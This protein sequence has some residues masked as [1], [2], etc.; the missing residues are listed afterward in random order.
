[1]SLSVS[2]LAE[3]ALTALKGK[4]VSK[5]REAG[6]EVDIRMRLR[7]EDRDS[8]Q[9]VQDLLV[10]SPL[11]ISVPLGSV[12]QVKKGFGPSEILR[13]DQERAVLVSADLAGRS[14]VDVSKDVEKI[15]ALYKNK[16]GVSLTPAGEAARMAESFRNLKIVMSL[17]ILFVFM[18]MAA[19]FESLWEPFLILFSI[20]FSLIA[21]APALFIFRHEVSAMAA[22]GVVLLGGIVVNNGIVLFDF[23]NHARHEGHPL[24]ESLR[25]GCS[26]RL[27]PIL[28][29]AL[30][31]I[32]GMTPLALGI[33][34][35]ADL[36]A[37]LAVVVTS[38]LL[39]STALTLVV[40]PA[41]F[42]LVDT[43]LF[44]PA[45]RKATWASLMARIG[46]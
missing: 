41:I 15:L 32:L 1:M 13:Y 10:H 35:G 44:D 36:Q 3:T 5:Y 37:P 23:V 9:A 34:E 8:P 45:G 21:M 6:R 46:R 24:L 38:G 12:A 33:G 30:T 29:T 28:M 4:V 20:P 31:T 39:V 16:P 17:S 11:D 25:L 2:D 26:T 40:L 14:L 22:M 42:V 18:I 27:R 43:H 19:Q 7:K